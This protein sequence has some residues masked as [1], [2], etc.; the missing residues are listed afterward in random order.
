MIDLAR[1]LSAVLLLVASTTAAAQERRTP[2]PDWQGFRVCNRSAYNDVQVAKAL[3]PGKKNADGASLIVSEGWWSLK[4]GEC[5]VLWRGPLKFRYYLVY[6]Q[7]KASQ[8][9]WAGDIWVCV[10]REAFT[11]EEAQCREGLN[12][13]KFE[14]VDT[15]DTKERFTY[16]LD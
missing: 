11:I 2:E 13:R 15:G 3:S 12:R 16:N 5:M 1:R 7:A 6:A 8:K 4:S 10:S 9:E 14:Q